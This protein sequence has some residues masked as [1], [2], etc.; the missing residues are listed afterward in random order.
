MY[1]D[2]M[3]HIAVL[4]G[5]TT[6]NVDKDKAV[7]YLLEDIDYDSGIYNVMDQLLALFFIDVEV[8]LLTQTTIHLGTY[9]NAGGLV[10]GSNGACYD[11]E[12]AIDLGTDYWN[13]SF[14]QDWEKAWLMYHELG[15]DVLNL[16]HVCGSL[17]MMHPGPGTD[18][19]YVSIDSDNDWE[20]F[21]IGRARMISLEG[22]SI[23]TCE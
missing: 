6:G 17:E 4:N 11:D 10:G 2:V 3:I 15:H 9:E 22:Q 12:I 13:R 5:G 8:S 20:A 21:H 19:C 23:K 14:F 18:G 7:K 16:D 1:T